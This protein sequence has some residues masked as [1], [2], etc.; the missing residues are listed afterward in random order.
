MAEHGR[1]F[2]PI[3]IGH[4]EIKNRIEFSPVIPCLASPEGWVT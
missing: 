1:L 3:R 4:V 2:E